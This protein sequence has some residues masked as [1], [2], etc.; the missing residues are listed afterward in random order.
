M[1]RFKQNIP[2]EDLTYVRE[3]VVNKTRFSGGD[4]G[5]TFGISASSVFQWFTK[6]GISPGRAMLLADLMTSWA[7]ELLEAS[8]QLREQGLR[9]ARAYSSL[10]KAGLVAPPS[11]EDERALRDAAS[12][13][14]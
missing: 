6:T 1:G 12:T 5:R 10:E 11:D 9:Y 13:I 3:L 4:I 7:M 2:P 8:S 14:T